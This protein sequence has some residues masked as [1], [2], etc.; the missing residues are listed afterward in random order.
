MGV[1]EAVL[2]V[3]VVEDTEGEIPEIMQLTT[4]LVMVGAQSTSTIQWIYWA[5]TMGTA[6]LEFDMRIVVVL[7]SV[8]LTARGLCSGVPVLAR[9]SSVLMAMTA[10]EVRICSAFDTAKL[11]I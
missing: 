4:I 5:G 6:L 11:C 7:T 8:R 3:E 10:I 1:E 9:Q 2:A